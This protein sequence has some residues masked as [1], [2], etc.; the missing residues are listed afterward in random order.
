MIKVLHIDDDPDHHELTKAQLK[1]FSDDI[2]LEQAV[3]KQDALAALK[4][5]VFDCLLTDDQMPKNDGLALY[6]ELRKEKLLLPVVLLSEI[7]DD[8][9]KRLMLEREL[10]EDEFRAVVDF[11][12]FNRLDYWIHRLVDRYRQLLQTD[13]LKVSLF[14]DSP[15]KMEEFRRAVRTLTARER[16][17]LSLIGSGKSNQ[18]IAHELFISYKTVKNH[19]YHLFAKLGIHTRAEAIHRALSLKI[20]GDH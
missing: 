1:Q 10:G 15:E 4:D 3:S 12:H 13:K 5:D 19:V 14:Q 16:E 9:D 20:G 7:Q 17:I 6:R 11:F 2:A 18:E 8:E